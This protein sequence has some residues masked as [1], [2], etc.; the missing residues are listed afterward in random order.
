M[1]LDTITVK[2]DEYYT[3]DYAVAPILEFVPA[4]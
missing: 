1:K 4:G 3:P 2:K